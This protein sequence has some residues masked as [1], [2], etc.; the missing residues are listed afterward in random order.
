VPE[1]RF[2]SAADGG[3]HFAQA[4]RLVLKKQGILI[5]TQATASAAI[6]TMRTARWVLLWLSV[7]IQDTRL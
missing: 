4:V 3:R 6:F 1:F 7:T 5:K 2:Q